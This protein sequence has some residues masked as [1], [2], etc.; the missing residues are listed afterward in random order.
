MRACVRACVCVCV[1]MYVY[2]CMHICMYHLQELDLSYH[3]SPGDQTQVLALGAMPFPLSR[4]AGP[5]TLILINCPVFI[6]FCCEQSGITPQTRIHPQ[7]TRTSHLTG[8]QR[9]MPDPGG[10]S[11]GGVNNKFTWG[12]LQSSQAES[13]RQTVGSSG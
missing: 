10:H 9:D 13:T 4:L 12:P 1:C 3:V 5:G 7:Q 8:N 2:A 6:H 11:A